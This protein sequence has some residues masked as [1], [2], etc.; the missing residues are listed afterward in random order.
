MIPLLPLS[1]YFVKMQL[2]GV[3]LCGGES[4]R[5]G[6]DKGLTPIH[7]TIW[8]LAM[9][10]KLSFLECPVVFSV[11]KN[12]FIT[13]SAFISPADLVEDNYDTS[14]PTRGLLTVHNRFP[15]KDIFLLSCDMLELD[16]FTIRQM[17]G[18]YQ[19]E[20]DYDYYAYQDKEYA[21]PFCGIYTSRGLDRLQEL[22]RSEDLV[23]ISMQYVLNNGFTK[24][25]TIEHKNAFRNF[26]YK[27]H[28]ME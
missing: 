14:G 2:L 19:E 18:V 28:N 1:S 22:I 9:A 10:D 7:N 24:R 16:E 8:A 12:Q 27:E 6:S 17:L 26:N 4:K 25:L 11:N 23:S 3:I 21:Q 20:S 5:M 13:Y 15:D